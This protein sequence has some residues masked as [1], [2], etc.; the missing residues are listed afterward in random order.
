MI[1]IFSPIIVIFRSRYDDVERE[2]P[3]IILELCPQTLHPAEG[4][5]KPKEIEP[6]HGSV[7]RPSPDSPELAKHSIILLTFTQMAQPLRVHSGFRHRH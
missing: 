1:L 3:V 6:K 7:R 5:K 2:E 4:N